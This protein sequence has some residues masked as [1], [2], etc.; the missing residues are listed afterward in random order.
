MAT[1][2]KNSIKEAFDSCFS[3]RWIIKTAR[4]TGWMKRQRKIGSITPWQR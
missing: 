1:K 3:K 4:E 2:E